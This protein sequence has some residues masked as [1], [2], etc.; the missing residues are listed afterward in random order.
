MKIILAGAGH[1]A[2]E[3]EQYILDCRAAGRG[4]FDYDDTPIL[5]AELVGLYFH[6]HGR[7]GDFQTRSLSV[8]DPGAEPP[9]KIRVLIAIGN[10]EVRRKVWGELRERGVRFVKLVHPTSVVAPN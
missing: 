4:I 1:F 6:E 3:V 8:L 2:L 7:L 9:S 10:A 5:D